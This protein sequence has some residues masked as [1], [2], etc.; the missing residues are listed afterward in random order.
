M[1]AAKGYRPKPSIVHFRRAHAAQCAQSPSMYRSYHWACEGRRVKC[2]TV[3]CVQIALLDAQTLLGCSESSF[4]GGGMCRLSYRVHK[5]KQRLERP[6]HVAQVSGCCELHVP[7]RQHSELWRRLAVGQQGG[8]QPLVHCHNVHQGQ[9]TRYVLTCVCN[10]TSAPHMHMPVRSIAS[11]HAAKAL[12]WG[13]AHVH[14][15]VTPT[16]HR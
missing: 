7:S 8:A 6:S 9:Q 4:E 13:M 11:Q 10:D 1:H 3:I 2:D 14:C 5:S 16:M 12:G 15:L